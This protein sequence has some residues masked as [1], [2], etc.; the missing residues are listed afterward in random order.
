MIIPKINFPFYG[1]IIVLS[2]FI[3]MYY[4]YFNLKKDG[5]K[6]KQIL[7][8][9][10]MYIVFAFVC[11]KMYT[12]LVYGE[13]SFLYAGLSAY[14]GLVGVVIAAIIFERIIPTDGS[15]TKYTILSLPLVYGLTKI[16]CSIVGCCGG[17]PYNGLFK[18]KYINT[19]DIW[20]FPI[21]I[22]ET[23]VF[24][25]LFILL[26]K[27]KRNKYINYISLLIVCII[28]FLLDFLRYEH[29]KLLITRNQIFSIILFFIIIIVFIINK[30]KTSSNKN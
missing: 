9:F 17:I 18:I 8:Y 12:S 22:V 23:I 15:I 27:F 28:K 3:G 29:I 5:Y 13:E 25:I 4:I 1:I 24:I 2:V 11:G 14:G 20:Q 10:I 6:N 19:L 16:A 26:N 30:F 21:Q 7:M